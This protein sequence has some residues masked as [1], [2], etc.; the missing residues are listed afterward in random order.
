[1]AGLDLTM[2]KAQGRRFTAGSELLQMG[3]NAFIGVVGI[4][5]SIGLAIDGVPA[6]LLLLPIG[7]YLTYD[8]CFHTG[9]RLD[10]DGDRFVW[11]A[12]LRKHEFAR[13]DVLRVRE[14]YVQSWRR[15]V[16]EFKDGRRPRSLAIARSGALQDWLEEAE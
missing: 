15:Y 9:Y 11:R 5:L 2:P 14:S 8:S 6:A 12:F 3:R 7:L 1:M 10:V 16:I 13:A 4:V